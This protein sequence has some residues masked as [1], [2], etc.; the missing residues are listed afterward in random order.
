ML[1]DDALKHNGNDDLNQTWVKLIKDLKVWENIDNHMMYLRTRWVHGCKEW[2]A[3]QHGSKEN[4]KNNLGY[5]DAEW[6]FIW[7]T[8]AEDGAWAVP[9]IRNKK[10]E[11]LKQNYA[12]ELFIKYIAHDIQCHIIVIDLSLKR[13]QF[14]SANH[15][16]DGNVK[17][18]SPLLLYSTGG[19]FQAVHQKDHNFFLRFAHDLET[20]QTSE[21]SVPNISFECFFSTS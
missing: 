11:V 19:H 17:L 9:S 8:M 4:D 20:G 16:K 15:L 13:V 2:L 18:D 12:P 3:G 14:C 7:G 5:T 1:N 6:E 10:G 21:N